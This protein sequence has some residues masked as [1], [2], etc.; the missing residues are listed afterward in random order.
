MNEP[1]STTSRHDRTLRVIPLGSCEDVL[2]ACG[3]TVNFRSGGAEEGMMSASR[4]LHNPVGVR[5]YSDSRRESD[6]RD[7]VFP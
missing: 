5:K 6:S 4:E 2:A 7:T 3:T 1:D